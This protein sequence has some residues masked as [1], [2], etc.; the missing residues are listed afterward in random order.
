RLREILNLSRAP[1][2]VA[3]EGCSGLLD[4]LLSGLDHA[5]TALF[6]EAAWNSPNDT[7]LALAGGPAS[8]AYVL[9]TSGSTG[10][11]KGVMI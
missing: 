6:A 8:L 5:P 3:S 9:F 11:P 10:M 2:L 1:L 7:P 4:Q